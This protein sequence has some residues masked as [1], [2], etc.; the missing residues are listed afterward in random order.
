MA[1]EY[2]TREEVKARMG[3]LESQ[4]ADDATIDALRE[5]ASRKVE[6]YCN[7]P[8]GHFYG[9]TETRYFTAHDSDCVR[10]GDL[11]SIATASGLCTDW[12]TRQ[13]GT[14]WTSSDYDL[15]PANAALDGRPYSEIRVSPYGSRSFPEMIERGVR[16]TGVFGY[17]TLTPPEVREAVI[18]LVI[19]FFH[20]RNSPFGV[21][22]SGEIGTFRISAIDPD[23]AAWLEAF[24]LPGMA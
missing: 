10:V 24:R 17:Q 2:A 7:R 12:G 20:R 21:V 13:Y 19:R 22:G 15:W 8:V 3:L 1:N 5:A 6:R 9:T 11:I 23:V 14:S 4:N 18:Q 16:V